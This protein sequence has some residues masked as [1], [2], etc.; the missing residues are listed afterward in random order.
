[1]K[2]LTKFTTVL[3]AIILALTFTSCDSTTSGSNE[4]NTG[5]SFG[6]N[7]VDSDSG[8]VN[9]D[10][11]FGNNNVDSDSGEGYFPAPSEL[12]ATVTS[13]SSVEVSW[14]PVSG[15][16]GY[17]VYAS[18][19]SS[20]STA[21]LRSTTSSTSTTITDLEV[22]AG[23]YFWV[24]SY[25]GT[26]TSDYSSYAYAMIYATI[27]APA[28]PQNVTARASGLRC[29]DVSWD[30]VEGAT[31]YVVYYRLSSEDSEENSQEPGTESSYETTGT[32]ITIEYLFEDK[33]YDFW[34]IAKNSIGESGRSDVVSARS[35]FPAPTNVKVDVTGKGYAHVTCSSVRGATGYE[36]YAQRDDYGFSSEIV[37]LK[38]SVSSTYV[39]VGGL[40]S[41]GHYYFYVKAVCGTKTSDF[42][43][44]SSRALIR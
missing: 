8:E 36:I 19:D 12:T 39:T 18:K 14:Y 13:S 32:Y 10:T 31:G 3:A 28:E 24:K 7:N 23:Y 38:S 5:T 34:V 41:G 43:S 40:A 17:Y 22:G 27:T 26:T 35:Y 29:I 1:M 30:T 37:F 2:R 9:T 15:A 25:N 11:S 42:S 44:P 6:N 20:S 4:V 33:T 21:I 16:T